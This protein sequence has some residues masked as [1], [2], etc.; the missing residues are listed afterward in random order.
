MDTELLYSNV[1]RDNVLITYAIPTYKRSQ[2]II[3][4]IDSIVNQSKRITNSEILVVNNDPESDMSNLIKRYRNTHISIYRNKQNI[5][6]VGNINRA[7]LLSKGKYVSMIHDDDMICQNYNEE[8][9]KYL[10]SSDYDLIIAKRYNM[11][12][13]TR[14]SKRSD[15]KRL[16]FKLIAKE[17]VSATIRPCDTFYSVMNVFMGP[18][19]GTLFR[20]DQFIQY[21][22]FSTDYPFAFDFFTFQTLAEKGYHISSTSNYVGIYRMFDSASNKPEVSLDF[23]VCFYDLLNRAIKETKDEKLLRFLRRYRNELLHLK[24]S[25]YSHE[26]KELIKQKY[27]NDFSKYSIIKYIYLSVFRALYYY[28]N[29]L[30]FEMKY[31]E[32]YSSL[33]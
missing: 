30:N 12:A 1:E 28:R 5:G 2:Y 27:N 8:I 16:L 11:Y 6:M 13:D 17:G 31:V 22:L 21:G 7:I 9:E 29:N 20:K 33:G 23:F 3:E 25:R 19:C 24:H 15:L 14:Q 4:T 10:Y 26:T 32:T 18:T